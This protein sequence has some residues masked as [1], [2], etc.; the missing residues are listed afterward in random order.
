MALLHADFNPELREVVL[1][2]KPA[3]LL[4]CSPKGTVPVLVRDDGT[5]LDESLDIVLWALPAGHPWRSSYDPDRVAENDG[6]L[7]FHLDRAKYSERYPGEDPAHH[8]DAA[9][10]ILRRWDQR[11]PTPGI[12][13]IAIFPFIRQLVAH[14]RDWFS[15]LDLPHTQRWLDHWCQSALFQRAMR[16]VSAWSP[17]Q[18]PVYLRE[19]TVYAG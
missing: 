18:P 1:R 11:D 6:P 9:A 2:D 19:P 16:K 15:S 14:D 8:R 4:A 5:V 10:E 12:T 3:A 13:D 17:G 7:K